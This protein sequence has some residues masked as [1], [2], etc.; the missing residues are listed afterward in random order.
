[1]HEIGNPQLEA[2]GQVGP[3]E[4]TMEDLLGNWTVNLMIRMIFRTSINSG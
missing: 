4:L 1:M 2:Q 3:P